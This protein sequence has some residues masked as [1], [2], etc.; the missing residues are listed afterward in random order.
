M[1]VEQI[2]K[3]ADE[4]A[5]QTFTSKVREAFDEEKI[6]PIP[7]V[8]QVTPF[9]CG[10][11]ALY[12]VLL[13]WFQGKLPIKR[14][15]ELWPLLGTN[16]KYGTHPYAIS[17]AARTFGLKSKFA[18]NLTIQDI[19]D[20]LK[21]NVTIILGFQAWQN[22]RIDYEHDWSS[23][24]YAVVVGMDSDRIY[25]MDPGTP[26]SYTYMSL[27]DLMKRWHDVVDGVPRV[28]IGILLKGTEAPT[29]SFPGS[30]IRIE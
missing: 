2:V 7:I 9:S 30:F 6:L 14:E 13:Y 24:H 22:R 18:S 25:L 16:K 29:T 17:L 3:L 23:G 11:A 8:H 15:Q 27:K 28:G 21:K 1:N 5:K 10:S 26:D 12:A 20:L 4:F 19:D